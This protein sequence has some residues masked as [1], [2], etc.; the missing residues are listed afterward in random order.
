VFG[1]EFREGS[2]MQGVLDT[3]NRINRRDEQGNR[4]VRIHAIGFPVMFAYPEQL[5]ITGIR[6]AILMRTLCAAND[7]T[8]VALNRFR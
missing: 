8:F 4:L 3:V 5:Q 2:S 7:G 1:D 6:F